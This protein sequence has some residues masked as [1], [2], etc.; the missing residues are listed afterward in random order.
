MSFW[1][2]LFHT[3]ELELVAKTYAP[4]M[5]HVGK[6]KATGD[7]AGIVD[8]MLHGCTTLV[9]KCTDEACDHTKV[10]VALGH[11]VE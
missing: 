9:W 11:E 2:W 3:H 4:P 8:R 5:E 7:G 10:V 1:R 6:F